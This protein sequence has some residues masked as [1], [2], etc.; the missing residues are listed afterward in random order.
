MPTISRKKKSR[1]WG[2]KRDIQRAIYNDV[3]ATAAW[4]VFRAMVLE[5]DGWLCTSCRDAGRVT[6]ATCVHHIVE[7]TTARDMDNLMMLAYDADNCTSLCDECHARTHGR[8]K[9]QWI[10]TYSQKK[11]ITMN[12][13]TEIQKDVIILQQ[14]ILIECL[15][16]SLRTRELLDK[17]AK[18]D[19]K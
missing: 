9:E 10:D 17:I 2:S 8:K 5:R 6:P 16:S 13:L 18:Y 4:R 7:L 15:Q 3:Y 12:K 11:R 19:K 14:Q 1:Q